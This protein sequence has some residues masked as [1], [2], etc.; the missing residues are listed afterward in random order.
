MSEKNFRK[1]KFPCAECEKVYKVCLRKLAKCH[2]G[3]SVGINFLLFRD[4]RDK[5]IKRSTYISKS[6]DYTQN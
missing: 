2:F 5:I 1:V 6:F 3:L 4:S